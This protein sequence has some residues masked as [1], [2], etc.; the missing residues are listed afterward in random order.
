MSGRSRAGEGAGGRPRTICGLVLFSS[1]ER[2][3]RSLAGF[4]GREQGEEQDF[5]LFPLLA[6][7]PGLIWLTNLFA[8]A[9]TSKDIIIHPTLCAHLELPSRK[10]PWQSESS[11]SCSF[12]RVPTC[13]LA[14]RDKERIEMERANQAQSH[15]LPIAVPEP[16]VETTQ[17]GNQEGKALASGSLRSEDEK[18]P[19]NNEAYV[20]DLEASRSPSEE[21][22]KDKDNGG[23]LINRLK[24]FHRSRAYRVV[25]DFAWIALLVSS[26]S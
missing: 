5:A 4:G 21:Q 7:I 24:S 2:T 9:P 23:S 14:L 18:A 19:Y 25:R 12:P 6:A 15:D 16:L 13:D 11:H 22:D 8:I 20:T 17:V 1:D 3:A 26:R 10:S